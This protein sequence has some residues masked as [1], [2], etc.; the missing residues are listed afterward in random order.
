M[1]INLFLFCF[2][3][4]PWL[5]QLEVPGP[6]IEPTPWQPPEPQ[7]RQCQILNLLSHQ[8][9]PCMYISSL[10]LETA[11]YIALIPFFFFFFFGLYRVAL[12][13]YGGSQARGL[14]G[15]VATSL[16][17]SHSNMGSSC[18][19]DPHHSSWQHRILNLLS[20]DRDRTCN[21]MVLVGFI[22]H[23]AMTGSPMKYL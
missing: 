6:G 10:H 14:I 20:K 9:I 22:N 5:Q 2:V 4:F 11:L 1:Q 21:L 13:A 17:Q 16:C 19:C 7:Q 8:G 12:M 23:W 3:F 18:V 15:S